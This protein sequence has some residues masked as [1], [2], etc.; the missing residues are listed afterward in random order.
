[1]LPVDSAS[2]VEDGFFAAPQAQSSSGRWNSAE[3]VPSADVGLYRAQGCHESKDVVKMLLKML[4]KMLVKMLMLMME[5][6]ERDG[7]LNEESV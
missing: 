1:M 4:V 5:R 6:G 7:T 2:D 3:G